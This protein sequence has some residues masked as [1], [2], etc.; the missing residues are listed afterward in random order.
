MGSALFLIFNIKI[1]LFVPPFDSNAMKHLPRKNAQLAGI[2]WWNENIPIKIT[3]LRLFMSFTIPQRQIKENIRSNTNRFFLL[4]SSLMLLLADVVNG[5]CW[6]LHLWA[7][8]RQSIFSAATEGGLQSKFH[9][10]NTREKQKK[11][12][13]KRAEWKW[14]NIQHSIHPQ[15][16][17]YTYQRIQMISS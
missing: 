8:L 2:V 15:S 12:R 13:N 14:H 4:L 10:F 16:H 3:W 9:N 5:N 6:N 17:P 1:R 7:A 11:I